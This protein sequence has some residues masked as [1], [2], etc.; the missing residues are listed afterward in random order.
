MYHKLIAAAEK[1]QGN[2][3][4]HDPL[5]DD[6][7]IGPVILAVAKEARERVNKWYKESHQENV[8]EDAAH[9]TTMVGRMGQCHRIWQETKITLRERHNIEWMSPAEMNPGIIFD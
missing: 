1:Q 9:I 5:E 6:P 7:Q 2:Q 3:Y 8:N 4:L